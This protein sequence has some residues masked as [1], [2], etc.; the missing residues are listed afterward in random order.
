MNLVDVACDRDAR[1]ILIGSDPL[2]S[3]PDGQ[4][5]TRDLDRTTSR[6]AMLRRT[7]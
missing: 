1:L 5:L 3:L 2:T 4:A 6:L 7:K